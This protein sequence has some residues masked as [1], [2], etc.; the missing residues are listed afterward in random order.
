MKIIIKRVD[1][2]FVAVGLA[3]PT[4]APSTFMTVVIGGLIRAQLNA[5]EGGDSLMEKPVHLLRLS[6]FHRL[7]ISLVPDT[8]YLSTLPGF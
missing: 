1:W 5:D 2:L 3:I 6:Y 8:T 7:F 4:L